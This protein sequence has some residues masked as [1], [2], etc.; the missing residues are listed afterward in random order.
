MAYTMESNFGHLLIVAED[1]TAVCAFLTEFKD[2]AEE[3]LNMLNGK[4][5]VVEKTTPLA[6]RVRPI[7][8]NED[9]TETRGLASRKFFVEDPEE[10][11][12]HVEAV[13]EQY[14]RT[15]LHMVRAEV[16][17]CAS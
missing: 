17:P 10:M 16:E 8:Q 7:F 9:G 5:A 14:G 13:F 2:F 6:F 1:G 11:D 3:T 12:Q 4:T 15:A